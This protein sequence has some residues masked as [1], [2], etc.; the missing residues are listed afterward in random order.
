M[1]TH[2][3][4][5][6]IIII[7]IIIIII[8]IYYYYCYY[9]YYI[10][11]YISKIEPLLKNCHQI[12]LWDKISSRGSRP[13]PVPQDLSALW[14]LHQLQLDLRWMSSIGE[15]VMEKDWYPLVMSK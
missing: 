13:G 4:I 1:Y 5:F 6:N 10:Y 11:I 12:I 14:P 15:G 3:Y 7:V 8:I 2:T 9:Y